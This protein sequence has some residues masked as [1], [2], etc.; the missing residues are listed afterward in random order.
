V[1]RTP[2]GHRVLRRYRSGERYDLLR[3]DP[4]SNVVATSPAIDW[5]P[6]VVILDDNTVLT[7]LDDGRSL[8]KVRFDGSAPEI[9]FPRRAE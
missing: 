2:S 7:T 4:R 6:A 8:A 3:V 9:V 1:D 5:V